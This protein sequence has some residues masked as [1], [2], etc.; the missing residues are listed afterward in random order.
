[1]LRFLSHMEVMAVFERAIRRA[2]IPIA[3]SRG[4]TP[5]MRLR[6]GHPAGV[7]VESLAEVVEMDLK[8]KV[9]PEELMRS[10]N[11]QLPNGL[12]LLSITELPMDH[13]PPLNQRW[14][15]TYEIGI[16]VGLIP[17]RTCKER[18]KVLSLEKEVIVE[19]SGGKLRDVRPYIIKI[20]SRVKGDETVIEMDLLETPSGRARP[21]DLIRAMFGE[22]DIG[23]V[24]I[25]R[26]SLRPLESDQSF[27]QAG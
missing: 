18:I 10:L 22:I 8:E 3:F 11:A 21:D 7:G 4:F 15:S 16:P 27:D 9:P 1:M 20:G 14:I 25:L 17:P 23:K 19:T 26:L 12:K 2:G 13:P 24:R 6:F 5:H